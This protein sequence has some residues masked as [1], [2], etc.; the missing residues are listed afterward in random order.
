V[1]EDFLASID[2]L[3]LWSTAGLLIFKKAVVFNKGLSRI[4]DVDH[5]DSSFAIAG[6]NE[7]LDCPNNAI[8]EEYQMIC[9]GS[10]L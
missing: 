1:L 5:E 3:I 7:V 6:K 9:L 2:L 10:S 8:R 4:A